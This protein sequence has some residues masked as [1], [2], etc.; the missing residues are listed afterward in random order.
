MQ[1]ATSAGPGPSPWDPN[2]IQELVFDP[3][4][5][6]RIA[7]DK[8]HWTLASLV[9]VGESPV[10]VQDCPV[11]EG[12]VFIVR[13]ASCGRRG[14]LLFDLRSLRQ[15]DPATHDAAFAAF[16]QRVESFR[17]AMEADHQHCAGMAL[18]SIAPD[19]LEF[20]HAM[21]LRARTGLRTAVPLGMGLFL[22]RASGAVHTIA[23]HDVW[24]VT[25][26]D[27]APGQERARRLTMV[28][29]LLRSSDDPLVAAVLLDVCRAADGDGGI[30]PSL[31]PETL[32]VMV[33]TPDAARCGLAAIVRHGD[34]A[35]AGGSARV[36][37][38]PVEWHPMVGPHFSTDGL[39][40]RDPA[41]ALCAEDRRVL[42]P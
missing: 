22:L 37:V 4:R 30:P 14:E 40:A 23:L 5:A 1:P 6:D 29:D 28:R 13:C 17:E 27:R 12:C 34:A 39:F 18:P 24:P 9:R 10:H 41:H 2:N 15:V 8:T 26:D 25:D 11:P 21:E 36:A 35:R 7:V 31:S 33:V 16:L 19:V 3:L 20:M 32:I 38:G 42:L